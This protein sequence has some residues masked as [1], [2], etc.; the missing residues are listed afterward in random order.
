MLIQSVAICCEKAA[1]INNTIGLDCSNFPQQIIVMQ[2]EWAK[3]REFDNPV[4]TPDSDAALSA[5]PRCTLLFS[6]RVFIAVARRHVAYP[7]P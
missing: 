3:S 6:K 1:Q 2:S 4:E 5:L 7:A